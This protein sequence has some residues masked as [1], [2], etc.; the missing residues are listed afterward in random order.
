MFNSTNDVVWA[1][2][3]LHV[4]LYVGIGVSYMVYQA[5]TVIVDV[6]KAILATKHASRPADAA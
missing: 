5:S 4:V 6:W 1:I 3:L 2:G